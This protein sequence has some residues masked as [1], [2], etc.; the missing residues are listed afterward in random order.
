MLRETSITNA[1][2]GMLM[3]SA[4]RLVA[5]AAKILG[6][7]FLSAIVLGA[8]YEH[9][10]AW[11][12]A[13]MLK[14]VGRSVDIGRRSLNLY[15]IGQG[16][17]TVVFEGGRDA[18]G[19][20]WTPTQRGVAQFTRACWY[21]RAG[22]GWSDPGPDPAWGDAAARDLHRLIAA[23][24]LAPPF[25]LVGHSFGGYVIR[26][27]N[28]MYPGQ[29][30]GMVFVDAALE[31]A[32]TIAGMPHRDRPPL[33]RWAINALSVVLGQ[34]GMMRLVTP[35][36]G[37]R[38]GDW[39]AQEWDVLTRLRRQRKV[40]L[41]DAH[42]GPEKTTADLM[43]WV[44]SLGDMPIIVLTQGRIYQNSNSVEA[45]VQRSWIQLQRQF[46]RQSTRGRQIIVTNSGHGIPLSAPDTVIA[47]VRAMIAGL[48]KG[49]D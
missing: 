15:C 3:K 21:D 12:D 47:A 13:R 48:R 19:Y 46:A 4:A 25:V 11:Q 34:L 44:D 31:D 28:H 38:P 17:P 40:L 35:S 18:P 24:G 32:G 10:A 36:P 41:A 9:V 14:Q 22:L 5:V 27:Y 16:S 2:K 1:R 6:G 39:S 30:A 26:L 20:V 43:R 23:A 33:P 37:P 29:V 8:I 7:L 49:H 42:L 45:Q